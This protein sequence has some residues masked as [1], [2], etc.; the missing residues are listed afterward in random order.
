MSA[1]TA[2]AKGTAQV[3]QEERKGW[4]ASLRDEALSFLK[5]DNNAPWAILAETVI[6]CV[7]IL[8]QLVDARDI[9]K[10]LIEVSGAPA[11]PL[12]WFNLITALIGLIPGGGD[13]VKRGLRS[14]KSG[15]TQVDDLLAII[16]RFYSGDPEKLLK[17]VLD[18]SALRKQLDAI[19]DN[20]NL[21]SRLSPEV[22]RSVDTIQANLG[23]QFDAFKKEVD[24]WLAKGRKSS[25]E[26]SPAARHTPGTP[27]AK[28]GTKAR[29]GSHS[30]GNHSDPATPNTPN[31]AT[32]R[33]ARFKKLSNKVLGVMG[34]HMA[35]YHCQEVKAW[36]TPAPHDQG[37]V[38]A[39]KLNDASRLVQLWPTLI[40]GRGIDAVWKKNGGFKPYAIIEAKASFDPTRTLGSLLGDAG[41]KT[42]KD[43]GNQPYGRAGR[44]GSKGGTGPTATRQAN[45]NVTQMS[46]E[47]I[48]NRLQ[49]ALKTAPN[50]WAVLRRKKRDAYT[51]HVLFFSIPQAV[52]HAEALILHTAGK[53]VDLGM[54]TTHQATREWTDSD[55]EKVVDNRAGL[56]G[57]VRDRRTR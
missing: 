1:A 37:L 50:D 5:G 19:L 2:A 56:K 49:K 55:I 52:A 16:R 36:G 26:A 32:Q 39:N 23:K 7:P 4:L 35:D 34:E 8:G 53:P 27:E 43:A 12:A 20:P 17:E 44:T 28:P 51:R 11:S 45:G 10:G 21:L 54:H 9:I 33:M 30:T 31:A 25:S 57:S 13:A 24:D 42:G 40:R 6:G 18:L 46:H 29:E 3:I 22:R 41:D 15:A 38:N 47:W 14:V 48:E